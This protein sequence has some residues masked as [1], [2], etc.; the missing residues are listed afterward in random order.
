MSCRTPVK[1]NKCECFQTAVLIA[2]KFICVLEEP[3]V[4]LVV[5]R[6]LVCR[7][8]REDLSPSQTLINTWCV[9]GLVV[10]ID[11]GSRNICSL[12]GRSRAK[13]FAEFFSPQLPCTF[14]LH[15]TSLFSFG[16]TRNVAPSGFNF[17]K[18]NKIKILAHM[19]NKNLFRYAEKLVTP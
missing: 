1:W 10:L 9:R 2:T 7:E 8:G 5:E 4:Q 12:W 16:T 19:I 13:V 11:P 18:K 3:Q 15:H 17:K 14:L 6:F